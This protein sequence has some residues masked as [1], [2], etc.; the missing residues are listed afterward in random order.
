VLNLNNIV[1]TLEFDDDPANSRANSYLKKGWTLLHVGTKLIDVL[2]NGQAL[3][4]T[5]YVVGAN[6]QQYDDHKNESPDD[7]NLDALIAKSENDVSK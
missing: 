4:N 5:T 6:Q 2:D 3:Y 7:A 1:F